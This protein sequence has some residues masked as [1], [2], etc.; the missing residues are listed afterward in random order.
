M[1]LQSSP[2]VSGKFFN[3][4]KHSPPLRAFWIGIPTNSLMPFILL[5]RVVRHRHKLTAVVTTRADSEW[6]HLPGPTLYNSVFSYVAQYNHQLPSTVQ[7]VAPQPRL[8]W[9]TYVHQC[10]CWQLQRFSKRI[11]FQAPTVSRTG[12]FSPCRHNSSRKKQTHE[13]QNP[14]LVQG[15]IAGTARGQFAFNLNSQ[16]I[17]IPKSIYTHCLSHGIMFKPETVYSYVAISICSLLGLCHRNKTEGINYVQIASEHAV[18]T[19]GHR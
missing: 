5:P 9:T 17:F 7:H 2:W 12:L 11:L 8:P 3:P 14:Y 6:W 1:L 13:Q 15:L 16:N 19:W 10:T 18:N 4:E